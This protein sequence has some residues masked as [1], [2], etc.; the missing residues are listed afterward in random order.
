[1]FWVLGIPLFT[2]PPQGIVRVAGQRANVFE[3]QGVRQHLVEIGVCVEKLWIKEAV[4]GDGRTMKRFQPKAR[5][6]AGAILKRSSN[7][8]IILSDTKA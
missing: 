8:R 5:G 1:M 4:V 3:S 6:S 2:E 7:I